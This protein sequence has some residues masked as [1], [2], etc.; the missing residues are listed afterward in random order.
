MVFTVFFISELFNLNTTDIW[1]QAI[2]CR[3]G[4][5][6]GFR[7]HSSPFCVTSKTAR[8]PLGGTITPSP[9][10]TSAIY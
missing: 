10:R 3:G 5:S 4:L 8:F 7:C 9:L 6:Y 1:T 2:H